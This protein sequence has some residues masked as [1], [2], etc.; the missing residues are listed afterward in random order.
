MQLY[1]DSFGAYLFV[2][3]GMF[4]VR[5]KSGEQTFAA[6]QLGAILL[7]AGTAMSADAALLA[8]AENIPLL[9]IDANTHAPLAQLGSGR[10]VSLAAIRRNQAVFTRSPEGFSWVGKILSQKI[11]AQAELLERRRIKLEKANEAG[12]RAAL[13]SMRQQARS[14]QEWSLPPGAD[15][16]PAIIAERF[17]GQE[18]TASRL[19]F[20]QIAALLDPALGFQHRQGH[21]AYDPFNALLNY[22]Y[23]MLYTSVHLAL[24]KSGLDPYMAV[25]HADQYGGKPTLSYDLIEPFRPW[26]DE[27]ALQL[28]E[29]GLL[30]SPDFFRPDPDEQG[31][32]LGRAGKSAAIDAMLAMLGT[33]D[34]VGGRRLRRSVQIDLEA[35]K[36]AVFLKGYGETNKP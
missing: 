17:R 13:K 30:T 20:Q 8:A 33:S 14:L 27:V 7:T 34:P 9:L 1:L 4:A 28:A 32:W 16:I 25:L 26:A 36:L 11:S 31:L 23:G 6:R 19:Y 18:G 12:F 22:G 24:L 2:R 15:F 35:Q 29:S 3:N 5:M 21:P 10:A